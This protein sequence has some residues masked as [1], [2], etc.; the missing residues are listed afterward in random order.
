VDLESL[1]GLGTTRAHADAVLAAALSDPAWSE[2]H[3]EIET[4]TWDVLPG[5]A[6]GAGALVDGLERE[7]RHVMALLEDAGWQHS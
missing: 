7:Y 2:L 5:E 1:S 6:R 3:L 4:Y